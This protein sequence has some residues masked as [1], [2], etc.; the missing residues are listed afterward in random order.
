MSNIFIIKKDFNNDEKFEFIE[1]KGMGHPDTLADALADYLSNNY[2]NY[3]LKKFGIILHH[4]FDK[5]G[6]LGGASFVCFGKGYLTKP[7]KVLINGRASVRFGSQIIPVEKL[8]KKWV[9]DFFKEKLYNFDTRKNLK[10]IFNLSSQS[11]PGKTSEGELNN[12]ARK[13]W[14]E[15]RGLKDIPEFKQLMA[16]DTSIGVGYAPISILEK[17]VLGLEQTLNS[18][19][20]K[21]KRLWMGSDIKIMAFR[22][23]FDVK[24]TICIPQIAD[25]VKNIEGYKINIKKVEKDIKRIVMGIEKRIN[26]FELNINTRDKLGSCEIYLTATGSSIESGD[27]GLVGRGNRVNRVISINKPMSIEGA[28]GKNPVY[29]IGK[30]YYTFAFKLAK[31]IYKSFK[32]KNEVYLVSQSGRNLLDPWIIT[33]VVPHNFYNIEKLNNFLKKELKTIP[34][35]TKRII[36]GKEV[37]S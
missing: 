25:K 16:N 18:K 36:S 26:N 10:I 12:S 13:F 11:S 22:R 3:T 37:L 30:I 28:C 27:E 4:N 32:I 17:I 20:Y 19:N 14:F 1:R 7:I 29:H 33:V 2:S 23:N 34:N 5:V 24:M 9:N 8:L 6:L 15:P 21:K 35:I 31:K